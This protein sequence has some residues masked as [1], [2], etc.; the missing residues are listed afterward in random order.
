MTNKHRA[1]QTINMF[2]I[3]IRKLLRKNNDS[4]QLIKIFKKQIDGERVKH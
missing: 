4:E 2:R 1:I 3:N